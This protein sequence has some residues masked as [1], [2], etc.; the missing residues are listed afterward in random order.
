MRHAGM[1]VRDHRRRKLELVQADEQLAVGHDAVG[2]RP[3][4]GGAAVTEAETLIE[5]HGLA[6]VRGLDADFVEL[7]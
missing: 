3:G 2:M 6:D 5:R 1:H 7:A 4:V